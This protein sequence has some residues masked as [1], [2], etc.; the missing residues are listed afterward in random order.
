MHN[1]RRRPIA[2]FRSQIC[3]V[4]MTKT[5]QWRVNRAY[6]QF[7]AASFQRQHLG[8]TKGLR[9]HWISRVEVSKAYQ[10]RQLRVAGKNSN[11]RR[12]RRRV[13]RLF[14]ENLTSLPGSISKSSTSDSSVFG[15]MT[16]SAN[17][18]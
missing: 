18:T 4:F 13:G 5:R 7:H 3:P 10:H 14:Y 9:N 1:F 15:L 12:D 8:I 16:S 17:F 2:D 11:G 6:F